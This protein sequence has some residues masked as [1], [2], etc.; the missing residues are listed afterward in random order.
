MPV[1][2]RALIRK[3]AEH[4][5]GI[6]STLEEVTLHQEELENINE[7]LGGTCRKLKI[8]Y[9]QNNIIPRM[10]NLV[11]L[12][13][14]VYLNLALNNISKIEG[15]QNCEFLSK[16]DLTVNF[17]DVDTLEESIDHLV[18]RTKLI[19]LYMMGNPAQAT[20]PGFNSF[21][22]AK[23]PQLKTLDGTDTT[24]SMQIQA[25]QKLPQLEDE[26][27]KLAEEKRAEKM[28]TARARGTG[29]E[30]AEEKSSAAS[31]GADEVLDCDE[32]VVREP[33][34]DDHLAMT[35]N[36]PEVRQ[37][38]YRELAQ[39]KKEK[40]DREK[41]QQPKERDYQK[42]QVE[43]IETTRKKEQELE[44]S[45]IKQKN[46]GGWD[47]RWD[48]EVRKSWI[49]LEVMIPRHLDSSLI[50]VD[51]HPMYISIVIKS[52]LL[53]LRLPVE[54]KAGESKCQRSK[55]TGS[56]VVTMPKV[57]PRETSMFVTPEGEQKQ[58]ITV[59]RTA[60][61]QPIKRPTSTTTTKPK[62]LS[63]HEQML[64]DMTISSATA[65]AAAPTA[66][67]DTGAAARV[68]GVQKLELGPRAA[69]LTSTLDIVRK[70]PTAAQDDAPTFTLDNVEPNA[71]N[72]S[73]GIPTIEEL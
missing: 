25:R 38:I 65:D 72:A 48:E 43:A 62:K 18:S 5:E 56:L 51:V 69:P 31:S 45:E 41:S 16:L 60:G 68:T 22:I 4:N 10:E 32:E 63:I 55:T 53:R 28:A 50:D 42:E 24:R 29:M 54:V 49:S 40:A 73:G 8:L 44:M 23:L 30:V 14:L 36:T 1:I 19:D 27:R 58:P 37:E 70:L 66:D 13:D 64:A 15:L 57:N 39:Q 35:E 2:T 6:I 20:W 34:P 59:F 11:H 7:V 61:K 17:I 3:R 26:L 12:K 21:V 46:E 47:F 33:D 9:L 52:K 71:Y 67:A